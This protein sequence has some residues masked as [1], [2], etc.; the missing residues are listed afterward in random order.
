[1][2]ISSIKIKNFRN[3]STLALEPNTRFNLFIGKNG[4]GKSNLLEAIHVLSLGR[5]SRTRDST[6]MITF[7][8]DAYTLFGLVNDPVQDSITRIG[9]EKTREGG[10]K[11]RI[12]EQDGGSIAEL[13]RILPIQ[14]INSHSFELLE[15]EPQNRRAFLDWILFHVEP[16]FYGIWQRYKRALQQR[17]AALKQSNYRN[18][19]DIQAWDSELIEAG[20]SIHRLRANVILEWL[21]FFEDQVK[22]LL[23]LTGVTLFYKKGWSEEKSL[24]DAFKTHFER[25]CLF[26]YT[27]Q[28]PH[29]AELS[30]NLQQAALKHILS[31][32]QTKL[33]VCGLLLAR[34]QFF[35]T[36]TARRAVFL[37]DDLTS[38]LDFASAFK[39]MSALEGLGGQT[40]ITGIEEALFIKLIEGREHTLFHVEQGSLSS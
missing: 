30:F 35:H 38:E 17:N 23:D 27:T 36:K 12:A 29:R 39:L 37:V 32:G 11:I 26:G 4:S 6:Q 8:E 25:D 21:T 34:A 19:L 16:S 10:T 3:L 14:L 40:L 15:A 22:A 18:K 2:H 9:L 5:S 31:R 13:A 28:G 1:M 20:E 24:A 33:F 7:G